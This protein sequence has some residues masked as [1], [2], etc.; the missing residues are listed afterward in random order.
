MDRYSNWPIVKKTNRAAGLIKCLRGEFVT[1]GVPVEFSSDGGP[2]FV[3]SETQS[4][5]KAWGVHHR[6]SSVAFPH[7]NCRAEVGVK[8]CKRLIIGNTGPNGELDVAQFQQAMLQYRNTPDQDTKMSPAMIIFGR[9]IRDLIPVLPGKYKPQ[10]AWVDNAGQRE[11]AL[12]K[13]HLRTAELLHAH[14]KKLPPLRVGD[15]V[16]VQ[17]QMG[18]EPLRWDKQGVVVEV[19]QYD[20]YM[21]RIDGSGRVTL[22]NRKFLRKFNLYKPSKHCPMPVIQCPTSE[23]SKDFV[24]SHIMPNPSGCP[25]TQADCASNG[26]A[27]K[28]HTRRCSNIS[29]TPRSH[30]SDR[31]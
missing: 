16:R 19:K 8:T 30:I 24:N 3:A 14:T 31:A 15:H 1:Y 11:T 13:R 2:E 10:Q 12:R 6:V 20:Q 18:N 4:F 27:P 22:R 28:D 26:H 5:L 17:N 21:V 23:S 7:S 25:S 9:C 29:T